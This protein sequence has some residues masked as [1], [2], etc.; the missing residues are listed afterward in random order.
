[1]DDLVDL[2]RQ[3]DRGGEERQVLRP[4]LDVPQAHGLDPLEH[5]VGKQ[6][7]P[8]LPK[9]SRAQREQPVQV[10][11]DSHVPRSLHRPPGNPALQVGEYAIVGRAQ[12]GLMVGEGQ[13]RHAEQHQNHE[14]QRAVARD[15]AQDDLVA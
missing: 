5:G 1:M 13:H 14:V 15:Q 3:E 10:A 11:Q 6:H 8:D 2:E 12:A 7:G 4:T 9:R